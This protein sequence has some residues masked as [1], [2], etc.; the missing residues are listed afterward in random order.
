MPQNS[1]FH[2]GISALAE[3]FTF[4]KNLQVLNLNDNI[5]GHKGAKALYRTLPMLT[6]LRLIN[7]GDCLL[8]DKGALFL[9]KILKDGHADLEELI[10]ESNEIRTSAALELADA[11]VAKT[12]LKIFSLDGNQI[13]I[14]GQ[15]KLREKL[16]SA[17]Q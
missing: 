5:I 6:K 7:F 1:I 8:K 3:S 4:N 9:S 17:G 2:V 16:Q 10:L 15:H 11:I 14:D 12:K 13:N